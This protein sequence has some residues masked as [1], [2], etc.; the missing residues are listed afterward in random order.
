MTSHLRSLFSRTAA[1]TGGSGLVIGLATATAW[2]AV[3]AP[4]MFGNVPNYAN[5]PL[6]QLDAGGNPVPGTGMRKFV[7]SLPQ[8]NTANN[9]GQS[10][11]IATPDTTTYPGSD[12]YEIEY[13]EYTKQLHSDLPATRLRG[14]HQVNYGTDASG[15]NTVAPPAEFQ[16]LGP[17]IVAQKNRPVRVKYINHLPTG[18]GGNLFIPTDTTYMGVGVGPNGGT[19][20]YTQNRSTT[21]LHG[22]A[23]PWISDGTPHQW[24]TPAGE[25]TSYATGVSKA[26]VPDMWFDKDS[27]TAILSCNFQQTCAVANSTNDPGPGMNTMYYT[28]EQSA[29]LMFYHDH[30]LGITRLNVYAGM[31][32]GYLNTD[33]TEQTLI[34]G[35]TINYTQPDGTPK[36]VPVAA[37]TLPG[38]GIPLV[39]QEKTFVPPT[40]G[41]PGSFT[42]LAGTFDSQL[43]AQDPTWD[44]A[45]WGGF[46]QLWFPHVYMPNQ[47]PS[48]ISGANAMGRWDYGPW[49]WPPYTGIQYGEIANPLCPTPTTCPAGEPPTVPGTP[50][51]RGIS[52]SGTPESFMDTPVV[53]GTAYPYINVPAGL[54][55]FR[56]LSV[57]ND[58]MFNLSLFVAASKNSP[59]TAGTTGAVLCD[60]TPGVSPSDCTEVKMVPFNGSQDAISPFPKGTLTDP[61]VW[62]TRIPNGFT[63]DDRAGGVPDPTTRGPAMI[64][65]GT[66][67]GFLPAPVVVYNQP[68]NYEYN[69]RNIVVGNVKEHALLIGPAERADVLVDFSKFAGK[70][71]I[72][73]NDSPAPVPAADPRLD[74]FTGDS[75]QTDT[76]GA[77]VTLPGYGP[78]TRTLMQIRVAGTATPGNT[79]QDY[80]DP[81]LQSTLATALPAAFAASQEPIIVPQQ[82]YDKVYGTTTVDAPGVNFSTIQG[83]SMTFAPIGQAALTLPLQ[84]K[85]IQELFTTDYG[86][87]NALLGI[88]IPNTNSVN[89]TTI[90]QAYIDPPTE[91]VRLT[92][93]TSTPA[94]GEAADGTQLWK[95]THNGVDTHAI[96]F[97]MFHVQVVNRV[98]WDGAISK[99]QPNELGWK[100]TVRMNPLEDIIV[101]MRPKTLDIPTFQVPNSWRPL[102][103]TQPLGVTTGFTGVDPNG[104]PVTVTN[105]LTNFGW[106]HVWHCH[107]LGHEENDMMRA[108]AIVAPPLQPNSLAATR[109]GNDA[110][111]TWADTSANETSFTLQKSATSDF[112]SPIPFGLAANTTSYTD[113]GAAMGAFYYRLM[114][115]NTVGSTTPGYQQLTA[116]SGWSNT[117]QVPQ[118]PVAGVSPTTLAFGSVTIGATS[119]AQ[120]VTLSNT[121][122]VPMSLSTPTISGNFAQTNGCGVALAAGATCTI[123]VT[124]KPTVAGAATGSLSVTT[125]D[126]AHPTLTVALSGTGVAPLP[127]TAPTLVSIQRTSATVAVV[128]WTD[129]ST[130]EARFRVQSSNNAGATWGNVATLTSTPA[131]QTGTGVRSIDVA[132][133]NTTNAIYRV[134]AEGTTSLTTPSAAPY[135]SLNDTV[136]PSAP[137]L[138]VSPVLGGS[139]ATA[140][141]TV[142][143]TWTDPANN[144]SV[145]KVYRCTGNCTNTGAWVA[146]TPAAGLAGNATSYTDTGLAGLTKFSYHVRAANSVASVPSN[147]VV[148]T[149]P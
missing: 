96:H 130:N 65:I 99:P 61:A 1:F 71:L 137:V 100:D 7:D 45:R 51:S 62:Y 26:D 31:A 54:V 91:L 72:L 136:A 140:N 120:T 44:T 66:E 17:I 123:S 90:P 88:E 112:A 20:E 104:L 23:T 102:D 57:A 59:T 98:G 113:K 2:G 143:L 148:V 149:T 33:P 9:L 48:D 25:T 49:F 69:R 78:N 19:E 10:L 121:G 125:N 111:L 55:R 109:V 146:I 105:E 68:V 119:A 144:N 83:T 5:S 81:A 75:D 141:R 89:Q 41:T 16:Y 133:Y 30:A 95:I 114:A 103:P 118:V 53:N 116:D 97:H 101:A 6:P 138:G 94:I 38:L 142:A 132:V 12:Y 36:T 40:T 56:I 13:G 145:Y 47:N 29:R 15:H 147:I 85:A 28:N 128:S 18:A 73:Y 46:G 11:P 127:P 134:L 42:N 131:Q 14:Y 34:N 108:L 110:V 87:M 79:A 129:N 126:T 117:A 21:H 74:Y 135:A 86:R 8:L 70:T 82:A 27:Y 4:D 3:T 24:T 35:G 58:R 60:G 37:G 139:G 107:I 84:P 124:F 63:F 43:A 93:A 77:P 67:G 80:V 22:G 52:P 122:V 106:E 76:G 32:G 50:D 64:Q 115:S 92:A 39:I